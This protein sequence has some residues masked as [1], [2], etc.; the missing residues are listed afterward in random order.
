MRFCPPKILLSDINNIIHQSLVAH[1]RSVTSSSQITE[2]KQHRDQLVLGWVTSPRV[3]L[4][5]MCRGIGQAS[6][7]MP[8]PPT[9][10][11]G[12]LVEQES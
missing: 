11:D 1:G 5:A 8:P 10:S 2:V 12:Y 9:S 6:H 4:M 3:T 7:V